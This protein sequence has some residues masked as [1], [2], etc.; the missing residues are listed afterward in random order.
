MTI[1]NVEMIEEVFR[2]AHAR[3]PDRLGGALCD[4]ILTSAWLIRQ[5]FS[6][7]DHGPGWIAPSRGYLLNRADRTLNPQRGETL[8]ITARYDPQADSAPL[9]AGVAN[10]SCYALV[11]Q[12]TT[13][14]NHCT[15]WPQHEVA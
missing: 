7:A 1:S 12:K 13:K 6:G 11:T 2:K 9:Q 10:E 5:T 4:R 8:P 3:H 14:P 15:A